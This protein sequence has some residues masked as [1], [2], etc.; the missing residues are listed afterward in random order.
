MTLRWGHVNILKDHQGWLEI[1]MPNFYKNTKGQKKS[2]TSETTSGSGSSGFNLNDEA[3]E[4][5]DAREHRPLGHDAA[6]AKKKSSASSR[7]SG[8]EPGEMAQESSKAVVFP[9]FDMHIYTSELS[10]SELRNAVEDYGIPL[11]LHPRLP[12]L[13]MTMNQLPSR[14]HVSQSVS[15]G[16]NRV[17]LFEIR[18]MSLN[19]NPTIPLFR[20]F[21]KLCKQGHWFSFKNKTG[22]R[23][24]KCF[25]EVTSS[26]KGWKKKN[27][28]LDRHVVSDAIPWRHGDT[29]LHDEFLVSY[30]DHDVA[31][32]SKFLVPLCPSPRHLLYVC[33]LTTTCLYSELRYDIKYQDKNVIDMD[34]FLK[35]PSWTGTIVSQGDPIPEDHL[36]KPNPKIFAPREKKEQQSLAKA[37]A[38][39]AGA[40]GLDEILSVTPLHQAASEVTKNPTPV[41]DVTQDTSYV[42]KEVVNLSGNTRVPTPPAATVQP[43]PRAEHHDTQQHAAS[44]AHSSQ[45][46]HQGPEDELLVSHRDTPAKDEFLGNLSNVEGKDLERKRDEWRA[47]TSN[48]VEKIRRLEKDLEP[49]TQLL[50]VAEEKIEGLE[51]EKLALLAQVAQAKADRQQLVREFI[52]AI[53]KRLQTS[54]EYR[55]SLAAPVSLCF[56]VG[57]LGGLS[58]GKI[59]EQIAQFL[60]EAKDLDIE[61]SKS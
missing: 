26:L 50:K 13:G 41:V 46:S 55:K 56:T 51:Y 15:M 6:N 22:G 12:P 10:S 58:L 47:T 20:V 42:K 36:Q 60:S 45:S 7:M 14:V 31:H 8:S 9:M 34:T 33:G 54:V 3:D 59:E 25:K 40:G 39:R 30:D 19:I 49:K 29:D 43:S 27:L 2:K 35:L 18:C 17:I 53:V 28:L 57:W 4:Y 5:E 38:K 52:P 21:Y 11:Y 1:E 61:G 32:L 48:Q 24:K 37:E 16:V 23:A 44:D